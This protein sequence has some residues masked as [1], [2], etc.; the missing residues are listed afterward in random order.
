MGETT[1]QSAGGGFNRVF[2]I[3][4][5]FT[6]GIGIWGL[7]DPQGMTGTMLASPTTC[8]QGWVGTGC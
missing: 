4:L 5:A 2:V 6:A 3:A 7:V 8:W 1:V